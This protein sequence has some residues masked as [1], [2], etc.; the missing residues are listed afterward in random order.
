[1]TCGNPNTSYWPKFK[2]GKTNEEGNFHKCLGEIVSQQW[3][4]PKWMYRNS[5][6][7]DKGYFKT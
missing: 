4:P 3:T 7:D 1:M 6:P 2:T 5:Q